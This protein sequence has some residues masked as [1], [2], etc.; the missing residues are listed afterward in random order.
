MKRTYRNYMKETRTF[1]HPVFGKNRAININ[2]EPWI[3]AAD[4]LRIFGKTSDVGRNLLTHLNVSEFKKDDVGT[5]KEVFVV[6]ESGFYG[7]VSDM[8]GENDAEALRL[9]ASQEIFPLMKADPHTVLRVP[10]N[11]GTTKPEVLKEIR[12]ESKPASKPVSK[13]AQEIH[14][15]LSGIKLSIRKSGTDAYEISLAF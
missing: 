10:A 7:L 15:T 11:E 8:A 1:T 6:S 5:K 14:T 2:N 9:W 13:A 12:T 3:V 4:I